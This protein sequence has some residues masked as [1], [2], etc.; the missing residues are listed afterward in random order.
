MP[1]YEVL[2]EGGPSGR[3]L[4]YSRT[5]RLGADDAGLLQL[6]D[7]SASKPQQFAVDVP[8]MLT[9]GW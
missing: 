4:Y 1:L 3:K 9:K 6:V 5:G 8:V 7:F 2:D